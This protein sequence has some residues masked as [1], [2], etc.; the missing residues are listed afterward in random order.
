[1]WLTFS[2]RQ[3][4]AHPQDLQENEV[5][6]LPPSR[7][8]E[9]NTMRWRPGHLTHACRHG[10]HARGGKLGNT[11]GPWE[12]GPSTGRRVFAAGGPEGGRWGS[13]SLLPRCRY[14]TSLQSGQVL[15]LSCLPAVP[16][17]YSHSLTAA[18]VS[19]V[20]TQPL[21]PFLTRGPQHSKNPCCTRFPGLAPVL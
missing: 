1:M 8:D 12:H 10:L 13:T 4:V 15:G 14:K 6:Y 5:M 17:A 3:L 7:P 9:R 18:L 16:E 20:L 21:R 11:L 19:W 2:V